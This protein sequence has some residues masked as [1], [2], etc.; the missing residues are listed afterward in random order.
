MFSKDVKHEIRSVI[1]KTTIPSPLTLTGTASSVGVL[2]TGVGTLFT[3]EIQDKNIVHYELKFTHLYDP[4]QN[5]VREISHVLSD[6]TLQLKKAFPLNMA[7]QAVQVPN[8]NIEYSEVSIVSPGASGVVDGV[9]LLLG[10]SVG[11]NTERQG[12]L[13]P[14]AIDGSV[15][16]LQVQLKQ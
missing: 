11:W 10:S 14:I 12:S 5:V 13:D 6:T 1:T 2:V 7:S 8:I 4:A 15:T 16:P 3:T 9:T